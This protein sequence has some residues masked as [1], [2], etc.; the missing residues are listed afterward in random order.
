MR[1]SIFRSSVVEL[2][3]LLLATVFTATLHAKPGD[4][5]KSFGSL[6]RVVSSVNGSVP[7]AVLT[8]QS[9]RILSAGWCPIT[10]TSS[11]VQ[12]CVLAFTESGTPDSTFA[13]AG[14]LRFGTFGHLNAIASIRPG[15]FVVVGNCDL[16]FCAFAFDEDG[17][18]DTNFG[19]GGVVTARFSTDSLFDIA[20]AVT[21]NASGFTMI[22]KCDFSSLQTGWD[23]CLARFDL[24]GQPVTAYATQGKLRMSI[25]AGNG[26]DYAD[27][28]VET[29]DGST[30]VFG[31]CQTDTLGYGET[32]AVK[33]SS[34]GVI[35]SSFGAGGTLTLRGPGV[36]TGTIARAAY[37]RFD[38]KLLISGTCNGAYA[39]AISNSRFCSVLVSE[40]GVV[41]TNYGVNGWFTYSPGSGWFDAR[42]AWLQ[43]GMQLLIVGQCVTD[44]ISIY[45][46]CAVR[47]NR[48]GM[49]DAQFALGGLAKYPFDDAT[50]EAARS[51]V[52]DHRGRALLGG[53]CTYS[54][55]SKSCFV[56]LHA[57]QDYF[58]LD[59][60]NESKPETDGILYVRHLLDFRDA[61]L[62]DGAL[63]VYANRTANA[64]IAADLT[65]P[66][67]AYPNC[68][69]S[70]VGAP[71]GANAMLDGV[72]LIRVMLGL[73]GDS[74][75]NGINFPAGTSRM[76]WADIKAHLNANCGMA[77]S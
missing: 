60:D 35:V 9:G 10:Q 59:D 37:R 8:L 25:S 4:L 1:S 61:V 5:D 72:V 47:V 76:T 28:A 7:N 16:A 39:N 45:D 41:D 48:D 43:N 73:S 57:H 70:V 24:R 52:F 55:A 40:D 20:T 51:I 49:L 14:V 67:A 69:S 26:F 13:S 23:F 27:A 66:S 54:D 22:G 15:A 44:G 64:E 50:Y 74:V 77:L 3:S 56:R 65:T 21:V 30:I 71:D 68:S 31:T 63:G 46:F 18:L 62:T 11:T 2:T 53:S 29:S 34:S 58:D 6:G 17:V 36:T 19:S 12:P 32:C 42:A 38:S 33:V 75:T